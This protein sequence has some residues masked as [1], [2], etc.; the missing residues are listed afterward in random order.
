MENTIKTEQAGAAAPKGIN[1]DEIKSFYKNS[2]PAI[3]K[4]VFAEPMEGMQKLFSEQ[5]PDRYRHSVTL[6]ASAAITAM[7]LMY[8]FMPSMARSYVP[9]KAYIG[10]GIVVA[11]LL[12]V[13]SVLSFVIKSTA[14]KA[15]L[16]QELLTGALCGLPLIV[17]SVVTAT[18]MSMI[19]D[20]IQSIAFDPM[21]AL[22]SAMV[23]LLTVLFAFLLM[24]NIMQ[25]SLRS[26]GVKDPIAW[27]SAPVAIGLSFY[28]TE[29]LFEAIFL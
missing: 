20:S 29:R 22:S 14:G 27:Y 17:A 24:T 13:I 25:R 21:D 26:A 23:P 6:I 18:S 15:D 5:G 10:M 28:L 4:A 19:G 8:V 12:V 2:F 3:F 9:F 16:K 7:V 1:T 11:L